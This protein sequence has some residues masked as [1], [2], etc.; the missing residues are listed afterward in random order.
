MSKRELTISVAI[1]R[2][3][4]QHE[5]RFAMAEVVRVAN[6]AE[7][8]EAYNNLLAQLDDQIKIYEDVHLQHVTLPQ[9][10]SLRNDDLNKLEKFTITAINVEFKNGKKYISA[11]GGKY[12]KFGVAIYPDSCVTDLPIEDYELGLHDMTVHNLTATI[13]LVDGKAQRVVSIQ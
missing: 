11:Q 1:N 6:G 8:R 2:H 4:G 3:Y 13:D 7:R 10:Q 9:G 12:A 5:I